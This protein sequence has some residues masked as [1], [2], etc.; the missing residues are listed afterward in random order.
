MVE[1]AERGKRAI[2]ADVLAR[3]HKLN[4][5]QTAALRHLLEHGK[6]TIRDF[7]ALCPATTRRSLQRDLKLLL[8]KGLV[9]ASGATNRLE[10]RLF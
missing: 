3:Q 4:A 10:H 7:E 8:E 2:Q 6:L 9:A 5:R 1:V